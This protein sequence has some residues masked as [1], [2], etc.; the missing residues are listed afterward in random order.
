LGDDLF[1]VKW[2]KAN[3]ATM[4]AKIKVKNSKTRKERQNKTK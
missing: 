2:Y 1:E 4:T 3:K